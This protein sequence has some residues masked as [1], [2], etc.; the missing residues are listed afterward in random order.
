M[1]SSHVSILPEFSTQRRLTCASGKGANLIPSQSSIIGRLAQCRYTST[2]F[3]SCIRNCLVAAKS[4]VFLTFVICVAPATFPHVIVLLEMSFKYKAENGDMDVGAEK[5]TT[6]SV[7]SESVPELVACEAEADGTICISLCREIVILSTP[8]N[9]GRRTPP[10]ISL[11]P[12]V[13]LVPFGRPRA[14][15]CSFRSPGD[16]LSRGVGAKEEFVFDVSEVRT[17]ARR[18]CEAASST[19]SE[20]E[21]AEAFLRVLKANFLGGLKVWRMFWSFS[22]RALTA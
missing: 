7:R 18:R 20:M 5:S 12:S 3:A 6:Q 8:E 16:S 9:E 13:M 10:P 21:I 15:S 1:S 22:E 11:M 19:A 4:F 2:F 14:D 17:G